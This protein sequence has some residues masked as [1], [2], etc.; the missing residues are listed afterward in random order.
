MEGG[1][2][3]EQPRE[4]RGEHGNT[5]GNGESATAT[6]TA[7]VMTTGDRRQRPATNTKDQQLSNGQ[8]RTTGAF[9]GSGDDDGGVQERQKQNSQPKNI[10]SN[11]FTERVKKPM[12]A[13]R[14]V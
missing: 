7:T 14:R 11:G 3:T 5:H 2:G 10:N 9:G 1:G 12:C 8:H 6:A 13:D 4:R